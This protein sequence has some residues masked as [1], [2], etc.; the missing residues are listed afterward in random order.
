[1]ID[2][3]PLCAPETSTADPNKHVY[4]AFNIICLPDKNL[5]YLDLPVS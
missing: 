4:P 5:V 2:A 3:T 1:M